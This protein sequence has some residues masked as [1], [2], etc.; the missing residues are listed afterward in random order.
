MPK[1]NPRTIIDTNQDHTYNKPATKP[2]NKKV[3]I[4]KKMD[5]LY[6]NRKN[7]Y[8]PMYVMHN[9]NAEATVILLPGRDADLVDVLQGEPTSVNFMSRTRNIFFNQNLNVIVVY[10]AS[11][12]SSD[13]FNYSYRETN[14]IHEVGK[15]IEFANKKFKK[16][17]WLV[18]TSKGTVSVVSTAI[19]FSNKI[20]GIVLTSTI[21]SESDG[22]VPIKSKAIDT[23]TMPVLMVHHSKDEC[24]ICV[25]SLA[26][27]LFT[28]FTSA[29]I[30]KFI[31]ITGGFDPT[32]SPCLPLH[33][34]GYINY[35]KETVNII[36]NWIKRPI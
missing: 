2:A 20:T 18:G 35:E 36:S 30:K 33:W 6:L 14:H 1:Q 24:P 28:K 26:A 16:P 4:T 23:L 32:G 11:D 27:D 34:H 13:D 12:I 21:T 5:R 22:L 9:P 7:G 19:E 31:L 8:L 15:V 25:P 17:I 10:R 3:V 29:T